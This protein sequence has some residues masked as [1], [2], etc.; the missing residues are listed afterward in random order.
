MRAATLFLPLANASTEFQSAP[1]VRA[2]TLLNMWEIA[3]K[4]VSIRAAREGGDR[5]YVLSKSHEGSFNPRRP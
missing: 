1:P 4:E 2:A 5:S 3:H